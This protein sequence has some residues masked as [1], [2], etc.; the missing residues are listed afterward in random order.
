MLMVVDNSGKVISKIQDESKLG[1]LTNSQIDY[2]RNVEK[3]LTNRVQ[4]MLEKVV[5]EGK[6]VVRVSADLDFRIM[7]KTEE[8]YVIRQSP[9][10]RSEQRQSER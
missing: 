9:V 1:R 2:Q 7:E 6:A 5:G 8:K 10:V 3:D 4:T